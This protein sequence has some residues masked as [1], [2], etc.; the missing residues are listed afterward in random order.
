MA[1]IDLPNVG[2]SNWGPKLNTAIDA[3]NTEVESVAGVASAALPAAQKAAASGVA[4]LDAGSRVPQVNLPAHLTPDAL[5]TAFAD[6]RSVRPSGP[7]LAVIGTSLE[8]LSGASAVYYPHEE[9]SWPNLVVWMSDGRIIKHGFFSV[10]GATTQQILENQLPQVLALDPRPN[11]CA[12]GCGPNE[13]A[14][15]ASP[16]WIARVET[17]CTILRSEGIDPLLKLEPARGAAGAAPTAEVVGTHAQNAWKRAY[18]AKEGIVLIDAFT[19]TV[20]VTGGIVA[21]Y[22]AD[23][24]H[25]H[26]SPAGNLALATDIIQR[27]RLHERFPPVAPRIAQSKRDPQDILGGSGVFNGSSTGWSVAGTSAALSLVAATADDG[28]KGSWLRMTRASGSTGDSN[29]SFAIP[30]ITIADDHEVALK[31]RT[32]GLSASGM[33]A[34]VMVRINGFSILRPLVTNLIHDISLATLRRI[35]DV[36][37]GTPSDQ[38]RVTIQMSGTAATAA[39]VDIACVKVV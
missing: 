15:G 28:I 1:D 5:N 12:V 2:E 21:A 38:A 10:P 20:D 18:A 32:S 8:T 29:L 13:S 14:L 25:V 33:K 11:A 17:I 7:L 22:D 34:S 16:E 27:Q 24:N 23:A 4:P 30:A 9:A 37:S 35:F 26:L 39:S 19:P 6:L 36:P 31:F 3:V